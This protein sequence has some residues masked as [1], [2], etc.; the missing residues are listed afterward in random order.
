M[1]WATGP[2]RTEKL[3][4]EKGRGKVSRDQRREIELLHLEHG[5][6]ARWTDYYAYPIMNKKDPRLSG[7]DEEAVAAELSSHPRS[8]SR[9]T[10]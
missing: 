4:S 5:E 2:I 1:K 3:D 8:S 9:E 7:S 10:V 6:C